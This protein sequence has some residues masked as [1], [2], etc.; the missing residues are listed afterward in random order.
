MKTL[1]FITML[2]A[3]FAGFLHSQS[4][5][6]NNTLGTGGSF[7][8][9]DGST[10]FLNL[11]QSDGILSLNNSFTF[12][13]TT[14]STL[15]VIFKGTDRFIHDYKPLGKDGFNTFMGVNSGN[16]TMT[17]GNSFSASYNT[18][19]GISS[20]TAL[21][22][23][24]MNSAFGVNTLYSN[25]T[26]YMNSAFGFSSLSSNIT[27]ICNSG[28][29]HQS[30][31]YNTS[32]YNSAFGKNSLSANTTGSNNSAFGY[33]SLNSNTTGADNSAFGLNSLLNN[34]TGNANSAFGYY[35]LDNNTAGNDNSAFGYQALNFTTG[36][37]NSAF[38]VFAGYNLTTGSNNTII[39]FNARSSSDTVS[40]EITL[41]NSNV[42][43][44]RC[45]VTT[46]TALSDARDKK[47]IR[48]LPLGLDF[49]MTVKPRLFNWD[50]REWY[51]D[52]KADGSKM[53]ENPTAG[54]IAQELDEVQ[55]KGHAEWL[56]LVLKSNRDRLE[57]TPGNLLPIMVKAIQELKTENEALR[58]ELVIVRGSIGE[59]IKK[60]V[61]AIL[62]K[63]D[64]QEE[65]KAK[66]SLN[67][68]QN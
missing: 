21:T 30:L 29:G 58:N 20:L 37:E 1:F 11:S 24:Y 27:G 7:I 14:G 49:L 56:N 52:G 63:I 17:G 62:P 19:V 12:P 47:N 31:L 28:F 26:G 16:F 45:Q 54:F 57:A 13:V 46:I 65:A 23:G 51:E 15:G 3:V 18:A 33:Q 25:T 10:T 35:S 41:G 2:L 9:K 39:G 43:N 6:I 40:N 48:D 53:R 64:Q 59:Q 42:T 5:S 66:V 34:I 60:E 55:T 8:I 61:R 22:S 50:R 44:L 4:G 67:E 68:T 38:G 36:N 32:S